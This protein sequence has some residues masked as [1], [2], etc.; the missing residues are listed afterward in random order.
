MDE[1]VILISVPEAARRMSVD[2]A[3][4]RKLITSGEIPCVRVG[5]RILV[6]PEDLRRWAE[7]NARQWEAVTEGVGV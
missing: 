4:M 7:E 3:T 2:P 1:D 5:R 6:R